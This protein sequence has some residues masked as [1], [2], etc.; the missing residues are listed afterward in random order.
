MTI[1]PTMRH[2]I[3]VK[4]S[5]P[6]TDQA[7]PAAEWRLG[8]EGRRRCAALAERLV[9]YQPTAIVTSIEPKAAET[10]ALV[11]ARLGVPVSSAPGL[12]EH[13]R[14]GVPFAPQQDFEVAVERFFTHPDRLVFGAET[15]NAAGERFASAVNRTL[16]AY[17][18]G[19]IAIVAHGTVISLFVAR[20]TGVDGF[21][22]WRR[23]GLPSFVVLSL[24][25]LRLV[26]TVETT[27]V[28]AEGPPITDK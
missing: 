25:D 16:T 20:R 8:N 22:L 4:H 10:G 15:A 27:D 11:A 9:A 23:L 3:L 1:E 2:L 28:D 26:T 7:V 19:T 17:S 21:A 5:L 18:T 13:D 12:H 24:P 6:D 14:R